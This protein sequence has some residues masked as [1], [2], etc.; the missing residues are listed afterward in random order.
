MT[1]LRTR[2]VV[3]QIVTVLLVLAPFAMG[4]LYV[5]QKHEAALEKM[6]QWEPRHARLQGILA[7]QND[8]ATANQLAQSLLN[9][10]VYPAEADGTKVAN[11]AQQRIKSALEQ[12][13]FRV[14]SIRVSEGVESGDFLR[15]KVSAR[16]DGNINHLFRSLL[17]LREQ[18]PVL[19]VDAM[20]F[21]NEGPL[22]KASVQRITGQMDFTVLRAKP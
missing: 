1:R 20:R 16:L 4:G 5:W 13:G 11:E 8:F 22:F 14:E 21:N 9:V 6:A 19:I 12:A 15:L 18:N 2:I 10:F 17:L 3:L 7:Q